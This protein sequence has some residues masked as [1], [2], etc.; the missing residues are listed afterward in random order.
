[1][2]LRDFLVEEKRD[3]YSNVAAKILKNVNF[4]HPSDIDFYSLC[5]L[6]GMK[7]ND[8]FEGEKGYSL[9]ANKGRRG[10]I[11]LGKC[12]NEIEERE[13]LAEEFS[14][15][16]LHQKDQLSIPNYEINKMERQAFNLASNL[17]IPNDWLLDIEVSPNLNQMF[18]MAEEVAQTFKV[19]AKF[20]YERLK[21]LKNNC[22]FK[23][24]TP[25]LFY[26][27]FGT[28]FSLDVPRQ[29]ILVVL[30]KKSVFSLS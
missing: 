6:Y 22:I 11:V 27:T 20:A 17:L 14:H 8:K 16:Y 12:K 28:D 21:L 15:L 26:H 23:I 25:T 24:E 5:D 30:N 18:I 3:Y 19:S 13:V 7:I 10:V 4:N 9:S 1:M 29:Q 2:I